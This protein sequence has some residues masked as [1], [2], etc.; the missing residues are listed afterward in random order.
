MINSPS[1]LTEVIE[2]SQELFV[3]WG[4]T[5]IYGFEDAGLTNTLKADVATKRLLASSTCI[6]LT[7]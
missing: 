6:T 4:H 2:G 3:P 7:W 1:M 5:P